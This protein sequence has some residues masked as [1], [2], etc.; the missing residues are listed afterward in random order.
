MK[1]L[2]VSDEAIDRLYNTQVKETYPDVQMLFGCGDLEYAYLEFLVTVFN[3]PLFYVPGNH[4][5]QYDNHRA[6]TRAEG[7]T[8]LD[9]QVT[10][11]N[12]LS[13]AGLGGSIRYRPSGPNQYTQLEMYLR[14]YRLLPKIL[15]HTL[16]NRRRLDVLITHSPP[17]GIHDDT[18]PAHQGLRALNIILQV[19]KPR[20]MLHGH[21]I[22]YKHNINSHITEY[23]QTQVVNIYPYRLMDIEPGS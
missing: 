6:R 21:T 22:F 10:M 20:F 16:M 13:I 17:F 3:V 19:V 18:D 9:G 11:A 14:V 15:L 12:G 8:N 5:P 2:A 7:G 4:D 1:I 23:Y